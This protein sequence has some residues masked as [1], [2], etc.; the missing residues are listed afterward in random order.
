MHFGGHLGLIDLLYKLSP[1]A[2]LS[3]SRTI[4]VTW[5]RS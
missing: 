2:L 5:Q 1:N 3:V 4:V